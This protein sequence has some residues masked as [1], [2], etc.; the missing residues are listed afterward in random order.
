MRRMFRD[1]RAFNQDISGWD[2]GNV[3]DMRGFV[4]KTRVF[5]QDLTGWN[6]DNV[7]QCG[8]FSTDSLAMEDSNRPNFTNC[9]PSPSIV[10]SNPIPN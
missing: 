2:V 6:V 8:D 4:S 1:A 5:N 7:T 9:D 10:D 3:T